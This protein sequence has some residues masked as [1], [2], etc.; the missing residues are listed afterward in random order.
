MSDWIEAHLTDRV[1]WDR[2]LFTFRLDVAMDFVPGQFA[3]LGLDIGTHPVHRP[4]S[5]ASAP[6]EPLEFFIVEVEG[7]QLSP[8]LAALRPGDTVWVRQR[9]TG[10]FTVEYAPD[11][12]VLWLMSTGTGL[13]PYISMLRAGVLWDRYPNIVVVQCSRQGANLAYQEELASFCGH[14][15]VRSINAVSRE[16]VPGAYHGRITQAF[17][18]GALERLGDAPLTPETSHVMLCGNPE[19]V[20]EMQS[21]LEERG[22]KR[23]NRR[24]P[25]HV[26][27]ERYW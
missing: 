15:G 21:L 9:I 19:M 6:G 25:G 24:Q 27:L 18:D 5:I 10:L 12:E 2:S 1:Q 14:H 13:A 8:R 26:T 17:R 3:T 22:M 7:G 4:Y 11:A 20:K 16:A 23:H